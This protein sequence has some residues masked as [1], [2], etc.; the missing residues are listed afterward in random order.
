MNDTKKETKEDK[1][2]RERLQLEK[3]RRLLF[4]T[5][6][7]T[8]APLTARESPAVA[9]DDMISKIK[10]QEIE[11]SSPRNMAIIPM[12]FSSKA[13]HKKQELE[14]PEIPIPGKM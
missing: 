1:E 6:T 3:D 10:K 8:K 5:S 12:S 9:S 13:T 11:T 4:G 14:S 7:P 2:E